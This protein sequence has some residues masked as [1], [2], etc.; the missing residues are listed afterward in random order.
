M[1]VPVAVEV[2]M[3]WGMPVTLGVLWEH[4]VPMGCRVSMPGG[5]PVLARLCPWRCGGACASMGQPA[6]PR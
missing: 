2:P 6:Q 3:P 4:R 1:G 5:A